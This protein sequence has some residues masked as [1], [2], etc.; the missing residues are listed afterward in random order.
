MKKKESLIHVK[1]EYGEA[2]ESK[3]EILSSEMNLLR[4]AK[5]IKRYRVLR[6]EE[7][8]IKT[9]MHRTLKEIVTALKKMQTSLPKLEIPEILK[10]DREEF[11][12]TENENEVP[13]IK[14][15]KYDE[16]I[17][18]QLQEIKEKLKAIGQ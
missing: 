4:I 12:E 11:E 1:L 13:E 15:D 7:L 16:G 6:S 14:E 17:E 9:K 10:K 3:R 8:K 18:S 2:L 5:V